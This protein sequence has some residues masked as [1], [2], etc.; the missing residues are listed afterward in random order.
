MVCQCSETASN[1]AR[2]F[3]VSPHRLQEITDRG[4][5]NRAFLV[6]DGTARIIIR[7]NEDRD[8]GEFFKEDWCMAQ[9]ASVGVNVAASIGYGVLGKWNYSVQSFE[10]MESGKGSANQIP[11]W[12]FLGRSAAQFHKIP[13]EGFGA[14]LIDSDVGR[15]KESWQRYLA[16]NI[17]SLP[18]DPIRA[19]LTEAEAA[20]LGHRFEQ[21]GEVPLE[22]GLCH[23]DLHP[24]N[25]VLDQNRMTLIDW[26]CAHAHVVP[27][28][29][30]R[31]L[32]RS[33]ASESAAVQAFMCGY[34][35]ADEATVLLR[36]VESILLLCSFD[37]VRWARARVPDQLDRTTTDFHEL[38]GR[39][40]I[41]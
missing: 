41:K 3:L 7:L 22:F 39:I 33:H 11:I 6:S 29:D 4:S 18:T 5:C 9:A 20:E 1:L 32:L 23:G 31:E 28:F 36:E 34:G 21:L 38:A 35:I 13:V 10:G 16:D 8:A 12:E 37:L 17:H 25:V 40:L 30:F 2:K 15:F 14:I 26:G 24:R 19:E 27:H